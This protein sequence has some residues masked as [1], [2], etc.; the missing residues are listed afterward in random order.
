MR[1]ISA[2]LEIE[3]PA[4][5]V[6]DVLVDF[7]SYPE[8]NPFMTEVRGRPLRGATLHISMRR[9]GG[10]RLRFRARV[11][12]A[13]R[14]SLLAWQG[15]GWAWW[16]G[17]LRGERWIAIQSLPGGRSRIEMRT[18]F[19]GLLSSLMVW[20]D[21]YLASFDEM[22]QALKRRVEGLR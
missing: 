7:D 4:E 3:A 5:Q 18:T 17:L 14:P 15:R 11:V 13:Q 1:T 20:L 8:W 10:W 9:P 6:W 21:R 19:T 12:A 16:P 22:E 2:Q